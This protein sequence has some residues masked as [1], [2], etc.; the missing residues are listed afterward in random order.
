MEAFGQRLT[1]RRARNARGLAAF[2]VPALPT[3]DLVG[4]R[5]VRDGEGSPLFTIG[6]ER[7]SG[8]ELVSV[9]RRA[10]V[11][12]LVDVRDKPVSRKADFRAEAL[13]ASC[14]AARIR[15]D[16]WPELGSTPAQRDHLRETGD[17]D[18]F[19]RRFRRYVRTHRAEAL[20]RLGNL[21]KKTTVALLCYERVHEECH[22]SVLA[23]LIADQ[24]Q[25]T[26]VAL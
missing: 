2:G 15:Y 5:C 16:T 22:R 24:T 21:A 17:I 26:V 14:E 3:E 12:C 19:R 18:G 13:R 25:A 9:L 6:Y 11:A 20:Q 8:E 1:K 4:F 7:R 10:R 23:D